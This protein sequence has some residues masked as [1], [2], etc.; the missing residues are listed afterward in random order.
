MPIADFPGRFGWGYDGVNWFAPTRLYGE[1]DDVRRFVDRA[2]ALGIGVILDVVYNHFG[3]DGNFIT[4]FAPEYISDRYETEWGG[5]LNF[6]GKYAFGVREYVVTNAR[7]WIEEF[8]FDGLRFDATQCIFDASPTH[9]L[10]EISSALRDGADPRAVFLVAE[11]EPQ[12]AKLVRPASSDG[13]GLDAVWNDD[14]HHSARVAATGRREAYY[15]DYSGSAQELVS[16]VKWGFLFQGQRYSWQKKRRGMPALDL[17]PVSFVVFL[18]NHDQ[19]ANSGGGE[20]LHL[21]TSPG[22]YRAL[23]ALALLAPGTPML[24]QGQEFA[25]S[26]PFLYFADHRADLAQLVRNGRRTF[27]AQFPTLGLPEMD[28]RLADPGDVATFEASKLDFSERLSHAASY[29]LHRDLLALRRADPTFRAAQTAGAVDGFVIGDSAFG[30]R[31]FGS[32]G[33]DRL[34]VV[35]LGRQMDL[36]SISDPLFAPPEN[37][38][39]QQLFTS[40]AVRYGGNGTPPIEMEDGV[41]L[42]AECTV[43]LSPSPR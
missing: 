36:P 34:I 20:R 19:I 42:S 40:N 1:P 18:Q 14:F 35:N 25:S 41:T 6:D 28:L 13:Y 7:Y 10:S 37:T 32:D 2:H 29:D 12:H 24:F 33:A 4:K 23:T 27:L 43:V 26:A 38:F 30:I 22:K 8:H 21:L 39:W 31:L 11:N 9:I 3:P 5:A 16:A 15:Q 17:D